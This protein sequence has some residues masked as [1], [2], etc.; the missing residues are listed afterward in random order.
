MYTVFALRSHGE[1]MI[2]AKAVI[3]RSLSQFS[4]TSFKISII[5]CFGAV[6]CPHYDVTAQ[7]K[8]SI[9]AQ[10]RNEIRKLRKSHYLL[11]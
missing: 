1:D 7:I 8:E 5:F 6:P 2:S 3:H 10:E 4:R 9:T 11:F